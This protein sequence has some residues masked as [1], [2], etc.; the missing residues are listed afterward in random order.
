MLFFHVLLCLCSQTSRSDFP[1]QQCDVVRGAED[2]QLLHDSLLEECPNCVIPPIVR[3][4]HSHF[5]QQTEF[6]RFLARVAAHEVYGYAISLIKHLTL[7]IE[8]T[9]GNVL[10]LCICRL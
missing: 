7:Y 10:L 5:S 6:Q 9:L 4:S 3:Q 8:N 2:I 1:Q